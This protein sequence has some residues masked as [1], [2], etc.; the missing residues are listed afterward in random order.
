MYRK[1]IPPN[2]NSKK[3]KQY[4]IDHIKNQ[5]YNQYVPPYIV[6]IKGR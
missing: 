2:Y 5:N 6:S 4:D 1:V 3:T